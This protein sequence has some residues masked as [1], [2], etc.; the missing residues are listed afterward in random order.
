MPFIRLTDYTWWLWLI[1][2]SSLLIGLLVTPTGLWVG[3]GLSTTQAF[4]FLLK[5]GSPKSFPAQLRIAYL[6]ILGICSIPGLHLL[7]W[8]PT[9]GTFALCFLG[10]CLLAWMLSLMPWNRETPLTLHEAVETFLVAPD[11]SSTEQAKMTSGCPGGV[12]T[13][14][15][16]LARM[17]TK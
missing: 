5:E 8:V 15:V 11:L 9:V 7:F 2:A 17:K 3:I 4:A 1:I 14:D 16:Q 6:L 13:L 10:Y 12:C